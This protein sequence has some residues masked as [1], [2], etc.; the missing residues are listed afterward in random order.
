[1]RSDTARIAESTFDIVQKGFASVALIRCKTNAAKKFPAIQCP[2]IKLPYDKRLV[3]R[4][5]WQIPF[6]THIE[7][8]QIFFIRIKANHIAIFCCGTGNFFPKCTIVNTTPQ[9]ELIRSN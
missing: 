7:L 4:K 1:M 3:L 8:I 6:V 9:I 5:E 2:K